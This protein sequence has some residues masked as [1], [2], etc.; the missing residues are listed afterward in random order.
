MTMPPETA[1]GR[2][3][4][5]QTKRILRKR[6]TSRHRWCA[7]PRIPLGCAWPLRSIRIL[8]RHDLRKSTRTGRPNFNQPVSVSGASP[9]RSSIKGGSQDQDPRHGVFRSDSFVT[10]NFVRQSLTIVPPGS[11]TRE[12]PARP[13]QRVTVIRRHLHSSHDFKE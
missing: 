8:V 5:P 10:R 7:S 6:C 9:Q 11:G 3:P 13:V 4:K 12:R 1:D 2:L